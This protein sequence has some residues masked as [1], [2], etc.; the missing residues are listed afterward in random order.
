MPA[1][2]NTDDN[3]II[4][5][6]EDGLGSTKISKIVGI[7]KHKVIYCLKKNGVVLEG[8]KRNRIITDNKK[9]IGMYLSG[10]TIQ[11]ISQQ[12]DVSSVTILNRLKNENVSRRRVG[13]KRSIIVDDN[14]FSSFTPSSC[15]W[16][17]FIAAD[18][19]VFGNE[20]SIHLHSNDVDHLYKFKEFTGVSSSVGKS[21]N[22]NSHYIRFRSDKIVADLKENF[23]IVPCKSLILKPPFSMPQQFEVHYI[24]GYFDGDGCLS[25]Y[26]R[27]LN[28]ELYSGSVELLEW[29]RDKIKF[30]VKLN[31]N[32][33]VKHKNGNCFRFS[34]CGTKQVKKIMNHLYEDAE[35]YLE[36]KKQ[37]YQFFIGGII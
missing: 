7:A 4:S 11:Q 19:C 13:P 8:P 32:V 12:L 34:F 23:N 30:H 31:S 15:Y 29:A 33:N 37:K 1:R 24:R 14:V 5:L 21:K 36:R 3:L 27:N 28:F 26:K 10:L 20:I 16:A 18:G 25:S 17:G 9:I 35:Y 2:L 6:Y 22:Q